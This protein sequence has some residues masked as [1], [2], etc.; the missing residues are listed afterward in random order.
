MTRL[1]VSAYFPIVYSGPQASSC[2]AAEAGNVLCSGSLD[3]AD[4]AKGLFI[5]CFE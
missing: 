1:H 4:D 2:Y 3:N 5:R